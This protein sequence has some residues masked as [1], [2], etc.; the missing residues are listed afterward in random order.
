MFKK[1]YA[2]ILALIFCLTTTLFVFTSIGYD[3][4]VDQDEDGDVDAD[5]LYVLS[6]EYGSSGDPTKNVTIVGHATKLIHAAINVSVGVDEWWFS[7]FISV[8]GYAKVT[9]LI[10]IN[11]TSYRYYLR[12]YSDDTT[13]MWWYVDETTPLETDFVRTYDVMHQRIRI[14]VQNLALVSR[15]LWVDVYLMA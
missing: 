15:R 5:D 3:P 2:L 14:L 13:E 12:A 9:V 10:Y 4:W 7:D 6:Q 8:D 1:R 11:T